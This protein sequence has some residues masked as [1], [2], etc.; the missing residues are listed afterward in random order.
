MATLFPLSPLLNRKNLSTAII[1]YTH[2]CSLL[3]A[4]LHVGTRRAASVFAHNSIERHSQCSYT[5][6]SCLRATMFRDLTTLHHHEQISKLKYSTYRMGR[7]VRCSRSI[8]TKL[9]SS[10]RRFVLFF[11]SFH[12]SVARSGANNN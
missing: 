10:Y 12:K 7:N 2:I 3:I 1:L 9:H 4:T 5:L 8:S 11:D 6:L